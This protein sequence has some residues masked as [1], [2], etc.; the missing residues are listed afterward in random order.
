MSM[1]DANSNWIWS[2]K[3]GNP[4][5]S[6][7]V[8]IALPQHSMF[9]TSKINLQTAAGGSSNNPFLGTGPATVSNTSGAGSSGSSEAPSQTY[10][11]ARMAHAIMSPIAFVILFPVGAMAIRLLSFP[12]L[13]WAHAGWMAFA[14][15]IV[16]ASMGM[17][18][19][20]AVMSHQIDTYHAIIGLVVVGSL[21]L[22]PISGM[23]HH[24]L[25][26]K[27]GGPNVATYPQ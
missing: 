26:K 5:N 4:V 24:L 13:V 14:Y 8:T 12:G 19:W 20:M 25:Y 6:D 2:Y 15:I 10:L 17:G 21:I 16:L 1:T 7:D 23:A 11:N 27:K 22:Q 3:T 18:V 9:G